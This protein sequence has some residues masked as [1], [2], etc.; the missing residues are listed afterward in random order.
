MLFTT[1]I[2]GF[3]LSSKLL[4]HSFLTSFWPC[5][6]MV[7]CWLVDCTKIWP[8]CGTVLTGGMHDDLTTMWYCVDWWNAWWSDHLCSLVE[9][10]MTWVWFSIQLNGI[11]IIWLQ[12]MYPVFRSICM[13]L[14]LSRKV[15]L[16]FSLTKIV[17]KSRLSSTT[18]QTMELF[19]HSSHTAWCL[20]CIF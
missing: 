4:S 7:L 3:V 20:L 16:F 19:C 12:L 6:H 2:Q 9:C 17:L 8:P 11:Y 18:R 13:C 5:H 1:S 10:I 15:L 14:A